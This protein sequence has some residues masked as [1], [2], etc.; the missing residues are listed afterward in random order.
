MNSIADLNPDAVLAKL[1]DNKIKVQTS[2]TQSHTIRAYGDE[3]RPNKNLAD[4]FIDVEWNGGAQ[5]LTEEPAL[6]KGNL[7]LTIWCKA[8][9]DGRAKKKL[10]K[11]IVSQVAP[12]VHRKVSQGFVFSF[13]PTNV[14]TPTTTNLTTGYSTTILN[15]E[16]HV[17][18]EFLQKQ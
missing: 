6:F 7:M 15:V 16:W 2:A 10:V 8:Q 11:Q 17:T 4:E 13:D 1:L 14:I 5:S 9:T 3:E 12:L 18:D